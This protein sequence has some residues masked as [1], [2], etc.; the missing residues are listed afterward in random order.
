M[1]VKDKILVIGSSNT[2]MT[3]SVENFP[4]PGETIMGNEFIINSGGK[5][6]NQAVAAARLGGNVI[7]VGKLGMD[8]FGNS[9][10]EGLRREGIDV[11]YIF[12]TDEKTSGVALITVDSKG[13]NTIIVDSGAN[14]TL[15]VE[16]IKCTEPVFE[17]SR[18]VL[19]QLE[20]PVDT[21]ICA[22]E[23]AKKH[24]AI[25]VLNPAPAPK[26]PLPKSLMQNVDL[27]IPNEIEAKTISGIQIIDEKTAC[28]A[29]K[30]IIS[31][32]VKNVIVT[33]GAE[34]VL[35]YNNGEIVKIPSFS[36]EV[37]DTTAAGD[38]FC[39]ALCVSLNHGNNLRD[40]ILF[41]NKASSITVT[42]R[43]AQMSMP[44]LKEIYYDK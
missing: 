1:D 31:F 16:D 27:L 10:A 33:M 4:K 23:M 11:S 9:T 3:M 35:V 43:G 2:D 7:F 34:G 24:G 36:V 40:A 14:G 20:T 17:R 37:V 19:M 32:G 38:T 6:A 13:E 15:S 41:A 21:L 8:D 29:M 5:G 18:I 26:I 25:V 44:H 22:A 12:R 42:R 28:L 39:G 30:R